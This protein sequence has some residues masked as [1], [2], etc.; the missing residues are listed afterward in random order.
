MDGR[1]S[2]WTRLL[3]EYN[4]AC[5]PL[6][7]IK[8]RIVSDFLADNAIEDESVVDSTTLPDDEIFYVDTKTWSL[9]FDGASSNQGYGIGILLISPE[10]EHIP[11]SVKLEFR[12]TNNVAE[13][14][15]CL[16]GLRVVINLKIRQL[17]VFGDSNLII[18]QITGSWKVCNEN[19]ALF[20]ECISK[21]VNKNFDQI[22]FTHLPQEDN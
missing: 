17:R 11:I 22:E 9:Y 10:G 2:R 12:V 5:I 13:Y 18:N 21:L 16:H 8:C 20:Q 19:L 14:E 15:A 6:K 7:C 3:S 4:L 1:I